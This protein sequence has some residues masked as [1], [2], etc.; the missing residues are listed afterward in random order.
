KNGDV[1]TNFETSR[2]FAVYR[3]G[4]LRLLDAPPAPSRIVEMVEGRD[5][6]I[7][8]LTANFNAEVLRFRDGKWKTFGAADGLPPSSAA[9][10][11]VAADGALWIACGNAVARLAPGAGRFE[12]FRATPAGMLSQDPEGRIWL[13]ESAGSYPLTGPGGRGT[14]APPRVPHRAG[15]GQVR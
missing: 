8:A 10:M 13:T 5:G 3:D 6:A 14:L 12:I 4:L 9:N 1:W 11:L 2:R 7:W 15:G